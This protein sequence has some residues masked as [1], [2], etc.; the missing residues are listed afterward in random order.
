MD[1]VKAMLGRRRRGGA[2]KNRLREFREH[3]G[4]TQPELARL[5]DVSVGTVSDAENGRG[6]LKKVTQ[7][8]LVNGLSVNSK[9]RDKTHTYS[10]EEVFP[11]G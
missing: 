3:E 5:A 9:K 8:K 2:P 11:N 1:Q 10:W 6:P 7:N 4:L